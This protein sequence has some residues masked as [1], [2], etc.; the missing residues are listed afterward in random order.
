MKVEFNHAKYGKT[1][2]FLYFT[3]AYVFEANIKDVL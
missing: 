2:P 1:I 3:D